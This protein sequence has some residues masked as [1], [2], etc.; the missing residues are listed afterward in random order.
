MTTKKLLK[1]TVFSIAAL[2]ANEAS[3]YDEEKEKGHCK[4]PKFRD[5]NL[6]VYNVENKVEVAPESELMFTISNWIAPDSITVTAKGIPLEV[7]VENKNSF[8]RVSAKLP[9]SLNGKFARINV[10]ADAVLGCKGMDGWLIKIADS[11]QILASEPEADENVGKTAA[12]QGVD[13]VEEEK[14]EAIVENAGE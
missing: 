13:K 3:A 5:F 1:L 10:S 12:E 7:D 11:P 6:P 8:F 2:L 4:A 14:V 9:A